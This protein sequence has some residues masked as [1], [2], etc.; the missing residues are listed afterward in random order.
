MNTK[1]VI[2]ISLAITL[3]ISAAATITTLQRLQV[4][5]AVSIPC[6]GCAKDF[7]PEQEKQIT[8]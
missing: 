7:A 8:K 3:V 2:L 1:M 6:N 4:A 5:Y